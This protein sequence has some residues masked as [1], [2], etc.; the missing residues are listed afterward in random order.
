M[1][2]CSVIP[3]GDKVLDARRNER[4][5]WCRVIEAMR[6]LSDTPLDLRVERARLRYE[7]AKA[8]WIRTW[9]RLDQV[10]RS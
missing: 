1:G 10:V 6:D 4:V 3:S 5:A 9:L 7:A 2:F 8:T